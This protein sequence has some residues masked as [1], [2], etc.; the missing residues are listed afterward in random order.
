MFAVISTSGR[1]FRVVEGDVIKVNRLEGS[2]GDELDFGGSILAVGEGSSLKVGGDELKGASVRAKI[3]EQGR[4]DKITI[5]KKKRRK[6][7]QK[8]QGHRQDI[9][10]LRITG[11]KV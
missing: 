1:Q 2:I 10:T 7:Y 6:G 3:L 8:K 5:F 4:A 9:T 11:I